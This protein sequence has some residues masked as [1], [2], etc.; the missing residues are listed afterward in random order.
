MEFGVSPR[1]YV[2]L[3]AIKQMPQLKQFYMKFVYVNKW[4]TI[5]K[6]FTLIN[7]CVTPY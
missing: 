2:I 6:Y 3:F 4:A 7:V 1:K 5:K